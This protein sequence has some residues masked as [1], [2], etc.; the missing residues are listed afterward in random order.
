M[1]TQ[2]INADSLRLSAQLGLVEEL[3]NHVKNQINSCSQDKY[4]LTALH[5]AVWNGH[6][7]C[8]KYLISNSDGI[9]K[10]GKK[11]SALNLASC[12]GWT[13]L[14]IAA[15]DIPT[16]RTKE[17]IILLLLAGVNKDAVDNNNLT[18]LELA[19]Q[20]GNKIFIEAYSYFE[21]RYSN[22]SVMNE[23]AII[24]ESLSKYTYVN[25]LIEEN[26][27]SKDDEKIVKQLGQRVRYAARLPEGMDIYEEEIKPLAEVGETLNGSKAYKCL[28]FTSKQA[29]INKARR[30]TLL[31]HADPEWEAPKELDE[32]IRINRPIRRRQMETGNS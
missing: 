2:E 27:L 6:I 18:A 16:S 25:R 32:A 22:E 3:W 31:K 21:S 19:T 11:N 30:E 20:N 17:I 4:G 8:V 12:K 24:Q 23:L 5:Y 26:E 13:A 10:N 7:E 1:P 9:D 29:I 14:H 28:N 15:H